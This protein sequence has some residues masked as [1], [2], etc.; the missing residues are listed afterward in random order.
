MAG[1]W[2]S[3]P[4]L[5]GKFSGNHF[6]GSYNSAECGFERPIALDKVK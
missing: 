4:I 2:G 6:P 5:N 3:N 1:H